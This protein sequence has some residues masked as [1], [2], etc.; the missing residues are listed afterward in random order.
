LT[1]ITSRSGLST[2]QHIGS[3]VTSY[4][5]LSVQ[6]APP[7]RSPGVSVEGGETCPVGTRISR[8]VTFNELMAAKGNQGR[9]GPNKRFLHP[10]SLPD[11]G[12][13]NEEVDE[14]SKPGGQATSCCSVGL[15]LGIWG[16][17]TDE[18]AEFYHWEVR[19]QLADIKLSVDRI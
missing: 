2:E 16:L 17:Y 12:T 19:Y 3:C 8:Q 15:R 5:L 11:V 14:Y 1:T 7:T 4:G 6:L 10:G 9:S 18:T 13:R